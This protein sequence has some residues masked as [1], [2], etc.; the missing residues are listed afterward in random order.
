[1]AGSDTNICSNRRASSVNWLSTGR[2]G[3]PRGRHAGPMR[4]WV[5]DGRDGGR[6]GSGAAARVGGR[7]G[8]RL[9]RRR[10]QRHRRR[11]R[12]RRRP[13]RVHPVAARGD[14]GVPG[15][16]LRQVLRQGRRLHGDERPGRDPPAQRAVRREA[17]P[18]ARRRDRRADRAQRDGRLLPAGGRP[19]GAVQGRRERVPRRGQRPRAAADGDRPGD[20]DGAV[21]ARAHGRHHPERPA[22]RDV[23]PAEAR[24]QAGAVQP[25]AAARAARSS[26]TPARS[27]APPRC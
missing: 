16:R 1:M 24:V 7:A 8:L 10:D 5:G 21:P 25:A 26:P 15:G 23:Q 19:A 20:P 12:P 22:D 18:R 2:A 17:G 27:P 3:R 6:P 14:V 9:S 4:G 13:A 11:L